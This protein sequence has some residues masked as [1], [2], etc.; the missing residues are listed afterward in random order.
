MGEP[1]VTVEKLRFNDTDMLGH[2]NNTMYS[3][4]L[5]AG[6]IELVQEAGLLDIA[7]GQGV[8]I[9][10]I[11]LDLL[12]EMNWPGEVR[13]E[14]VVNKLGNKSF[15]RGSAHRG[16]AGRTRPLASAGVLSLTLPP[17]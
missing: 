15:Q 10:R 1:R 9:A 17:A 8:V 11:E 16:V 3:V 4:A 5:E 14:T 2:I 13:S 12:R 7:R 6:R